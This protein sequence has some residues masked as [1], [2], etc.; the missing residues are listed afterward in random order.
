[1]AAAEEK[2]PSVRA[3]RYAGPDS[4]FLNQEP[5]ARQGEWGGRLGALEAE[6]PFLTDIEQA[7][8]RPETAET[9]S[10]AAF[11]DKLVPADAF[12]F[13]EQGIINGDNRLRVKDTTAV[14]WRWMCKILVE[15]SRGRPVGSGTGVLI[16]NKHVLTAA[17]VVYDAYKNMQQY[18][19]TVI[20][21]LDDL[22]E[23][24]D[25]YALASKPKIRREYDPMAKDSFNWDYAL[26]TLGTAVGQKQFEAIHGN[27]LCYWASPECGANTVFARL[28]P[29]LLNGKAAYTAGYATGKGGK[30]LWCATGILHSA[31]E[32]RRIMWTTADTTRGQSGSPV[33][34]IDNKKNCLVGVAAGAGTGS[35]IVVRVTR[36]LVHQLRAWIAEDG[37]TP[38]M[39]ETEEAFEPPLH[40]MP[41]PETMMRPDSQAKPWRQPET[42]AWEESAASVSTP[43]WDQTEEP[44]AETGPGEFEW[45][46]GADGAEEAAPDA[47]QGAEEEFRVD[48]LPQKAQTQFAKTDSAAW[49]DAVDAA[50]A[51]GVKNPNDL[52]DLIFFMQHRDR[53]DRQVGKPIDKADPNFFKLRAEWN[54]YHTIASRRLTPST[55]CSVFL[56]ARPSGDYEQYVAKPTTG[57][58]TLLINGRTSAT[59][60]TDAFDSMQQAVESL[61]KN[62]VVYLSAFQFNTTKLTGP[63][64]PGIATWTDLFV[65]KAKQG[66][67]IRII[68]TDIPENGPTGWKSNL[69]DLKKAVERSDFPVSARDNLKYIVSMHP[70]KLQF[71]IV[72]FTK[73]IV[74]VV[75]TGG[76]SAHVATHHQKFMVV[77]EDGSTVAYCGGL[78]I[79]PQR[80]PEGWPN[81]KLQPANALVW[82]DTHVKLEGLI[83][84]DL[85]REFI[86]RWNRE[87]DASTAGRLADWKPFENLGQAPLSAADREAAR[88]IHKLQM[89]RTVSVGATPPDIR[90]DD[91]WQ[92]Y[93]RLI[94]C[95]MRYLYMENQY[96][97]VPEMA[98]AIVKQAEAQPDLIVIIVVAFQIDDPTNQ[99]TDHGRALQNEFFKR[100]FARFSKIPNNR[101]R[102]YTMVGRLVHAKLILADDQA[103]SVGSTNADA[104]D[105]FMDTQL[106]VMLDAPEA[107]K[108][109]RHQLWSHDLGVPETTVAAWT[110]SDFLP[111]WDLIAMANE[112]LKATPEKMLGEGVVPFDPTTVKGKLFAIPDV[113]TEME[114]EELEDDT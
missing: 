99:F 23:P 50:I 107:A 1:M 109:F 15:D 92:G 67:K 47:V 39:I 72:S 18:T 106:N 53:V 52:A 66:V 2:N 29:R 82:H 85:E 19:I 64:P 69:D 4:P 93:F 55:S 45:Q 97:H 94:G 103:L 73:K 36:E 102:V 90:R 21:A 112:G 7:R 79:S 5:F 34:I 20:P 26:L 43:G 10:T 51:A 33:W 76:I 108:E 41:E 114:V 110:V 13:E 14:P 31:N 56:P 63:K 27:P 46:R 111:Q 37:E 30:S 62:D 42:E 65:S 35:N 81:I 24:F 87:K 25:R 84:R 40:L 11:G 71:Q 16:S 74:K 75:Q 48:R 104:R 57:R 89:H 6:S 80:T 8:A 32:K 12:E 59:P 3:E 17:H 9:E 44:E 113:L 49:R 96:F 58:I 61:G 95:A 91:V 28:D 101:L 38:A 88:N 60:K 98:D 100:L 86:L 77:I 105:F 83:A 78:D 70:A 22:Q 54:L 68:M